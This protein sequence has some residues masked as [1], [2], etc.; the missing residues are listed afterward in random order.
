MSTVTTLSIVNKAQLILQDATGVRWPSSEL[1]DWLNEGQREVV[2]FKP[3]S[4]VKNVSI[5]LAAGTKQALPDDGIQLIDIVRNM[6]TT[7]TTP[8]RSIRITMREI[9]D[10]QVPNWH[11]SSMADSSVKH[12]MYSHL[13][14]K[15]FY[16][17]PAQPAINQG[18]IEL[19]YGASPTN[20]TANG[21]ISIDDI[22][23]SILLDYILYRAYSK[24]AEY[25]ADVNRAAAHQAAYLASL[26]GKAKVETGLNPNLMAP[27]NPNVISNPN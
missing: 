6:G 17:Y 9:L 15:T 1:L 3:N 5:K 11:D 10:A 26:T 7:G 18:Y 22:Y 2:L 8:G 16:V 24:D 14:P 25:A 12:Y 19:V 4:F 23:Q 13:D 27:A 20:A 21:T